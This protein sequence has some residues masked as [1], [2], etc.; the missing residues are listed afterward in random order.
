[1]DYAK[2]VVPVEIYSVTYSMV[3]AAAVRH[4]IEWAKGHKFADI[5]LEVEFLNKCKKDTNLN[6]D[7]YKKLVRKGSYTS[8]KRSQ[9]IALFLSIEK[10]VENRVNDYCVEKY[11]CC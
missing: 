4:G 8:L 9:R 11:G 7:M 10:M 3:A 5:R 2:M 6:I 1:M